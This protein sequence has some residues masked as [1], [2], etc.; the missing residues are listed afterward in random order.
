MFVDSNVIDSTAFQPIGKEFFASF[1]TSAY[2]DN[3]TDERKTKTALFDYLARNPA[4]CEMI[5]AQ[6]D[7]RDV[8]NAPLFCPD[9]LTYSSMLIAADNKNSYFFSFALK[10][11]NPFVP[12]TL[13]SNICPQL[14]DWIIS[15]AKKN[16]D[17]RPIISH[18]EKC[19]SDVS[20][21][22]FSWKSFEGK[23]LQEIREVQKKQ[24]GQDAQTEGLFFRTIGNL[25][26]YFV[27]PETEAT[28]SK[29]LSETP[30]ARL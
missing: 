21:G 24:Q 8:T 17:M 4:L 5:D 12:G 6:Y 15:L 14:H 10:I 11:I 29:D 18:L 25:R 3:D 30:R 26:S 2:M 19:H 1:T 28:S 22:P 16:G 9:G 23:L 20:M 13:Y 7:Q 27:T